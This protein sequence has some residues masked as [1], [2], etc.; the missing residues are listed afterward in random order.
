[1]PGEQQENAQK[2][3]TRKKKR[4]EQELHKQTAYINKQLQKS[5]N[6]RLSSETFRNTFLCVK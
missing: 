1:M 3:E 4:Y 6:Q 2:E 5:A